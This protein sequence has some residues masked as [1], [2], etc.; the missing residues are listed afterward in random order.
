MTSA[1]RIA[2]FLVGLLSEAG[3]IV[4]EAE[5]GGGLI[6]PIGGV[7]MPSV[8]LLSK[9]SFIF[10][11]LRGIR[12]ESKFD[13]TA[14]SDVLPT[15]HRTSGAP[16]LQFSDVFLVDRCGHLRFIIPRQSEAEKGLIRKTGTGI[17]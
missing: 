5:E 13:L 16:P 9:N 11:R 10:G 17:E 3:I 7:K 12:G 2:G 4:E 14:K 1:E 6:W 15:A 8:L